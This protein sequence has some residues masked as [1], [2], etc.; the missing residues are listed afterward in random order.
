MK[1]HFFNK[2]TIELKI[3]FWYRKKCYA[4]FNCRYQVLYW[5]HLANQG[6]EYTNRENRYLNHTWV[7]DDNIEPNLIYGHTRGFLSV[8]CRNKKTHQFGNEVIVWLK[9]THEDLT[10]TVRNF[11][12][13]VSLELFISQTVYIV[14]VK[15][16]LLWIFQG[17]FDNLYV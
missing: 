15:A 13:T 16:Y 5:L 17:Q 10:L 14:L 2:Q 9:L 4:G 7:T 11:L 8:Y 3:S 1:T 12:I 6:F